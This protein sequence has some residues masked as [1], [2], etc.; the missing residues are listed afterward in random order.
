MRTRWMPL[1]LSWMLALPVFASAEGLS[2]QLFLQDAYQYAYGDMFG[3]AL[4]DAQGRPA[5]LPQDKPTLMFYADAAFRMSLSFTAQTKLLFELLDDAYVHVCIVWEKE[6][7]QQ[8]ILDQGLPLAQNYS[9]HSNQEDVMAPYAILF[10]A[11]G[12]VLFRD[13]D[14][15]LVLRKLIEMDC[16]P[17]G[18]LKERADRHILAQ[19]DAADDRTPLVLFTTSHMLRC[20]AVEEALENNAEVAAKFAV[21]PLYAANESNI[22]R[23]IDDHGLLA[24]IYG[25]SRYPHLLVFENGVSVSIDRVTA[26]TVC[27]LLLGEPVPQEEPA[28]DRASGLREI[29]LADSGVL[30]PAGMLS[31]GE[32][33]LVADSEA[34]RLVIV[35]ALGRKTGEVG[36]FGN[37]PLEFIDPSGLAAND[38][39]VFVLDAGN[40]RIQV[41]RHDLAYVREIPLPRFVHGFFR[42]EDIAATDDSIYLS[43]GNFAPGAPHL[44]RIGLDSPMEVACDEPFLGTIAYQDGTLYALEMMEADEDNSQLRFGIHAVRPRL[45]RYDPA[46]ASLVEMARFDDTFAPLDFIVREEYVVCLVSETKALETYDLAGNRL[47]VVATLPSGG[48]IGYWN[49]CIAETAQGGLLI[50]NEHEGR[51]FLLEKAP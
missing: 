13:E 23:W 4:Y 2:E 12:M 32:D 20:T 17:E 34:D 50:G 46:Q 45:Y 47:D 9:V 31:L 51:L 18:Y 38:A 28:D 3:Q 19:M 36:G 21:K 25:I 44:Y 6:I 39:F 1:L 24:A 26:E 40:W 49:G 41:L 42:Y 5:T 48:E 14:T 37:G 35:D 27:P 10:D 11:R 33:M 15:A 22:L 29:P 43:T 7:P 8:H 30:S 16:F